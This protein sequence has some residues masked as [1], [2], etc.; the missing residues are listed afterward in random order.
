MSDKEQPSVRLPPLPEGAPGRPKDNRYK[1]QYGVIVICENE[2]KQ[3]RVY[4]ALLALSESPLK[5]RVVVT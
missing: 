4:K 3:E 2:E 5:L 1:E